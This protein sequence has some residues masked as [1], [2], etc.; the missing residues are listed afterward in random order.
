[1]EY[2]YLNARK[3]EVSKLADTNYYQQ[4]KKQF[5]DCASF[6]QQEYSKAVQ[7]WQ[8]SCGNMKTV[9]GERST[10]YKYAFSHK[11]P[12]PHD[13]MLE[14]NK[15][16]KSLSK[17]KQQE[18]TRIENKRRSELARQRR[19]ERAEAKRLEQERVARERHEKYIDYRDRRNNAVEVLEEQGFVHGEDFHRGAAITFKKKV[20]VELP[21]GTLVKRAYPE[22]IS[23]NE[24]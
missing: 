13:V 11:V 6:N 12:K 15:L 10:Q 18:A 4:V 16:V 14:W 21:S 3:F 20:L 9:F 7:L 22:P 23:I 5:A 19:Q 17:W 24:D 2:K 1:M 8:V